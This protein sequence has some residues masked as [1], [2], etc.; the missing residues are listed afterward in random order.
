MFLSREGS[1]QGKPQQLPAAKVSKVWSFSYL[2][3]LIP[4][5]YRIIDTLHNIFDIPAT[6]QSFRRISLRRGTGRAQYLT[7]QDTTQGFRTFSLRRGTGRAQH[8][9][10]QDTTQS[11]RTVSLR[12]GTGR[13][14][15]EREGVL[16]RLGRQMFT[17]TTRIITYFCKS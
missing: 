17:R 12:R 5:I 3:C 10:T 8:L 1:A 15:T 9:T 13:R 7:T 6:T 14:L 4:Q 11:F 2:F 16:V